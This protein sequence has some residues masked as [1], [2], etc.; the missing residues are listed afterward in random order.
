MSASPDDLLAR[1]D[2]DTAQSVRAYLAAPQP[3]SDWPRPKRCCGTPMPTPTQ[4]GRKQRR[5]FARG[6]RAAHGFAGWVA[7]EA[8]AYALCVTSLRRQEEILGALYAEGPLYLA[9]ASLALGQMDAALAA[10]ALVDEGQTQD[11]RARAFVAA[12]PEFAPL[13][14]D[15]AFRKTTASW[16]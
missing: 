12:R 15:A 7:C 4:I 3:P 1:L 14:H 10:L 9:A 13:R 2:E 6:S 16:R 8:G 5:I 11:G